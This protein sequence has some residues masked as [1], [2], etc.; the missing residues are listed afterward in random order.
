MW[1]CTA[2]R[3]DDTRQADVPDVRVRISDAGRGVER[4]QRGEDPVAR[5][6]AGYNDIVRQTGRVVQQMPYQDHRRQPRYELRRR[7]LHIESAVGDENRDARRRELL[8]ERRQVRDGIGGDQCAGARST[9]G[10]DPV[11]D[12]D[13]QWLVRTVTAGGDR[14][15]LARDQDVGERSQ[16]PPAAGA[17]PVGSVPMT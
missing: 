17:A 8:R 6:V 2:H 16:H 5:A 7:S 13:D 11:V 15:A 10:V 1:R 3:F 14:S 9:L 4:G 12:R